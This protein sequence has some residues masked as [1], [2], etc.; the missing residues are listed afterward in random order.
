MVLVPNCVFYHWRCL[1]IYLTDVESPGA[2]ALASTGSTSLA[3]EVS[4][5]S[6]KE[7]HIAGINWAYSPVADVNSD[8]RNP[9]IGAGTYL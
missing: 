1:P 8:E 3:E 7:M 9:V 2:M 4:L 5:A 6:A